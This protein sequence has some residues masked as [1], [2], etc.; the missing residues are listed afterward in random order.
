MFLL[1][2]LIFTLPVWIFPEAGLIEPHAIDSGGLD[3]H[4]IFSDSD[5][6]VFLVIRPEKFGGISRPK[7]LIRLLREATDSG[8]VVYDL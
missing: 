6:G 2:V 3:A 4:T 7:L 5:P 1:Y 8:H